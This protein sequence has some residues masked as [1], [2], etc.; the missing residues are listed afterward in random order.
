MTSAAAMPTSTPGTAVRA[1]ATRRTIVPTTGVSCRGHEPASVGAA[2]SSPVMTTAAITASSGPSGAATGAAK[3]SVRHAV[4]EAPMAMMACMPQSITTMTIDS[5]AMT[6][7]AIAAGSHARVPRRL[8]AMSTATAISTA[9][10]GAT[11]T[12]YTARSLRRASCQPARP[13][14]ATAT[15]EATPETTAAAGKGAPSTGRW[16]SHAC[17]MPSTTS[18]MLDQIT[19]GSASQV[20][21]AAET[22]AATSAPTPLSAST[23]RSAT[24]FRPRRADE[25][26]V[27]SAC[28]SPP[29]AAPSRPAVSASASGSDVSP[30]TRKPRPAGRASDAAR[31][32]PRRCDTRAHR[33][34]ITAT[35]RAD[36]PAYS[37]ASVDPVPNR[38]FARTAQ[39]SRASSPTP[40]TPIPSAVAVRLRRRSHD[41]SAIVAS[42][43]P[44]M[45]S[46]R[47]VM[48]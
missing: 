36:T 6:A 8:R 25:K 43:M 18:P 33:R 34:E 40:S 20:K 11:S 4:Q 39:A 7:D 15:T 9:S 24:A 37:A 48:S 29:A 44:P 22:P 16:A 3:A 45:M 10:T 30:P 26:G 19:T 13:A 21:S 28:A 5:P 17:A 12:P 32:G 27:G 47:T 23:R 46:A 14:A 42:V 38:S 2:N 1:P 35:T 31:S 41:A